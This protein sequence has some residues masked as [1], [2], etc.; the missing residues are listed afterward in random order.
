MKRTSWRAGCLL[1]AAVPQSGETHVVGNAVSMDVQVLSLEH[2]PGS[3]KLWGVDADGDL[4]L[5]APATGTSVLLGSTGFPGVHDLTLD[6]DLGIL[7]GVHSDTLLAIDPTDASTYPIG[8]LGSPLID[9]LAFDSTNRTLYAVE[10]VW[11]GTYPNRFED[12]V[13]L[14]VDETTGTSTTLGSLSGLE[15]SFVRDMAFDEGSGGLYGWAI[16]WTVGLLRIDP[17]SV[18]WAPVGADPGPLGLSSLTFARGTGVLYAAVDSFLA[19][20]DTTTGWAGLLPEPGADFGDLQSAI[21][22]ASAGDTLVLAPGAGGSF[23]LDKGLAILG[24]PLGPAGVGSASVVGIPGGETALL[25]SLDIGH[26]NVSECDGF[27]VLENVASRGGTVRD[28]T[29]V[30]LHGARLAGTDAS[31]WSYYCTEGPPGGDALYVHDSRLE[32]VGSRVTGGAGAC[33]QAEDP[34]QGLDCGGGDG[35]DRGWGGDWYCGNGG[36][37]IRLSDS[38]L[39]LALSDASGGP[40]VNHGSSVGTSYP[41]IGLIVP[42]GS[43]AIVAGTPDDL[44]D[45]TW[46]SGKLRYSGATVYTGA[47]WPGGTTTPVDPDP[48]L[49]LVAP[50]SPGS[51]LVLDAYGTPGASV[52]LLVGTA[53]SLLE[54]PGVLVER[55]VAPLQEHDL[56]V[57]DPSGQASLTLTLPPWWSGDDLVLA[58][59]EATQPDGEMRRSNSVV[60]PRGTFAYR[61]ASAMLRNARDT[62]LS[63]PSKAVTTKGNQQALVSFI[64][65]AADHFERGKVDLAA[66]SLEKALERTDGCGLRGAPDGRGG[67]SGRESDHVLTCADQARIA[68]VLQAALETTVAAQPPVAGFSAGPTSGVAPLDVAFTNLSS[69][70]G[71][72]YLWDFGDGTTST[73]EN[74]VHTYSAGSHT[75]ALTVTRLG[76]VDRETKTGYIEVDLPPPPVADFSGSPTIGPVRQHVS[77][78]DLSTGH[79]D[80][81]SWD[82]GDGA[83]STDRN[84]THRYDAAGRYT[85][86]LDVTGFGGTDTETKVDYIEIVAAPVARF[87]GSPTEGLTPLVVDFSDLSTGWITGWSWDFGDGNTST[88]RSPF[89]TYTRGGSFTVSLTVTGPG[90]TRTESK[91]DYIDVTAAKLDFSGTPTS[92]SAP[93]QVSFTDLTAVVTPVAWWWDFGDGQFSALQDPVHT[94]AGPGTY[95]VSLLVSGPFGYG[96]V[97]RTDYITVF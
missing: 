25:S 31:W 4:F 78:T 39:H 13:L 73:L 6:P 51:P 33:C 46:V 49:E 62:T 65:Q 29:D 72:T 63:L 68:P 23:V 76:G 10:R 95:T 86:R 66:A 69:T 32:L 80:G 36:T 77:F 40:L 84:P 42:V 5:I 41:G 57:L 81:H 85:V 3:G 15:Y 54:T 64:S 19:R 22:A 26:L 27:V 48:T 17:S 96:V 52:I 67:G 60:L 93:L 35:L 83:T 37:G 24:D 20:I 94:Y 88:L 58:Q 14:D 70:V 71:S 12:K 38:L 9:A 90:G 47:T 56:G 30:R 44:V 91:R 53:P 61:L 59:V 28:S 55:L 45:G 50:T 8:S 7:Y 97:T 43:E 2:D 82:F 16:G 87:S 92:G 21:H 11:T 89:H 74:P 79:V 75:V 18:T 34:C 1:L